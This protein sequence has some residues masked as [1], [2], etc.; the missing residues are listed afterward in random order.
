M[1]FSI[2]ARCRESGQLGVAAATAV[3]A[4]G[5]LLTWAK[6]DA[7]AVATQAWINPYLGMESLE[8]LERGH[9]A[10]T[11]L[12]RVIGRDPD[13]DYRQLAIV[14]AAGR[15]AVHTGPRCTDWAGHLRGDGYTV[16]GNLL[17]DRRTLDAVAGGYERSAGAEFAERLL[18]ALEAGEQAGGD[19][20]G[21]TSAT[22]LV[23]DREEYPLWDMRVDA[24]ASPLEELRRLYGVFRDEVVPQ[25]RRLPKR[26]DPHGE[27]DY[28]H[29]V[30]MA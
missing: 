2:V 3:P 17:V 18:I 11:T 25:V 27:Q 15:S 5:K 26:N 30:G 29:G 1:T 9:D 16:Q 13:R 12:S 6:P 28:E 22:V 10:P 23:M 7:G 24:H 4:V 20:R 14:D 8:L 19:K 21:H